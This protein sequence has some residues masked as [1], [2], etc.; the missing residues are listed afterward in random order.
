[1][2]LG[3]EPVIVVAQC[4]PPSSQQQF[5]PVFAGL[6]LGVS[7]LFARINDPDCPANR[8][9]SSRRSRRSYSPAE[10]GI[11]QHNE[12][13]QQKAG[14]NKFQ[15]GAQRV[16]QHLIESLFAGAI[17]FLVVTHRSD[18]FDAARRPAA[19]LSLL[20]AAV[21]WFAMQT[22]RTSYD[23][24]DSPGFEIYWGGFGDGVRGLLVRPHAR[25]GLLTVI[26]LI[27]WLYLSFQMFDPTKVKPTRRPGDIASN[28]QGAISK[29]T[30]AGN[31]R[32]SAHPGNACPEACCCDR[33]GMQPNQ[34]HQSVIVPP[35]ASTIEILPSTESKPCCK[36]T[37][38]VQQKFHPSPLNQQSSSSSSQSL[39][40]PSLPEPVLPPVLNEPIRSAAKPVGGSDE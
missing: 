10:D 38:E 32:C 7:W 16:S 1:M 21:V 28:Q 30:S 17:T 25:W 6:V 34:I 4:V 24:R 26:S 40:Q 8:R 18:L 35:P 36:S 15:R 9:I 39:P 23:D 13:A 12:I 29:A 11:P 14:G 27:A 2:S 5:W 31:C 19:F 22:A 3:V 33:C 37:H 20:G